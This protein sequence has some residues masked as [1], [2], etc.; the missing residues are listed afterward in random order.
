MTHWEFPATGPIDLDI[1]LLSGQ[2]AIAAEATEVM[3]VSLAGS[4]PGNTGDGHTAGIRV[5]YADGR[6]EIIEPD[7]AG[8]RHRSSGSDL[9]VRVP[10]GS[11][12]TVRTSASSVSCQGELGSLDVRTASGDVTAT[13]VR[14]PVQVTT[15]SGAIDL[16]EALA[17]VAAHT[18]SG[19]IRL[20]RAGG[21]VDAT[22]TSG[23]IH[24]GT[25]AASVT[26]RAASGS[27]RV[28]SIATGNADLSCVSG[29]VTVAV[30]PGA[31]VYLDLASVIGR[32]SSDLEPSGQ[33]SQADLR[34]KCRTVNGDVR[35][36]RAVL[37]AS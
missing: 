22:T 37:A 29:D 23:D 2:I 16:D 32:V 12:C 30:V 4:G 20:H 18:T 17:D 24:I 34:I 8:I 3:T 5:E 19:D 1:S 28:D 26:A 7:K 21:E 33:D 6:L 15:F 14:G 36:T 9:A 11:R 25:A 31:D 35:V 27:V 10:V 13:V